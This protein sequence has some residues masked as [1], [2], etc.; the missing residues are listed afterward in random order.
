MYNGSDF[1]VKYRFYS[2]E[3]GGRKYTPHQGYR[4][5]WAYEIEDEL[6]LY[7]IWPTFLDEKGEHFQKYTSVSNSGV[8]EMT[9]VVLETKNK[10]HGSRVK[11]GVK[12]YFMEGS[13]IVAEAE[14]IE[15]TGLNET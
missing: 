6:R 12:G 13:K 14:V 7:R 1:K 8:A 11:V 15:V 3:E 5:D 9:I 4:S 10:L 2:E